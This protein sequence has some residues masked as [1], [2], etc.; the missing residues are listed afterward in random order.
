MKNKKK[1]ALCFYGQTRTFRFIDNLYRNLN[2]KSDDFEFYF[3]IS[4]WDDF[5]NKSSFDFF[6]KKEFIDVKKYKFIK[7][8]G[9]NTHHNPE[10]AS[11]LISRVNMLKLNYEL[12]NDFVFD[13]VW[14]TISNFDITKD[15]NMFLDNLKKITK[16]PTKYQF[17]IYGGIGVDESELHS[18][19]SPDYIFTGTSLAFDMYSLGWKKYYKL[20]DIWK[21]HYAGLHNYHAY[22]LKNSNLDFYVRPGLD[23]SILLFDK[24]NGREV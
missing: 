5:E 24:N 2:N 3:F 20:S 13:Y 17:D 8:V 10:R 12:D 16:N 18:V 6:T 11:Y 23:N 15:L 4:T 14:L 21:E 9:T 19:L 1:I 7:K 22:I